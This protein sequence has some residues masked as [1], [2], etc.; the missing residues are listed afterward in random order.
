[1]RK[2]KP[3]FIFSEI[4]AGFHFLALARLQK[5]KPGFDFQMKPGFDFR[6]RDPSP[7]S[8]PW[9]AIE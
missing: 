3:G 9:I 5:M 8:L 6:N 1:L 4:E 7:V 2:S